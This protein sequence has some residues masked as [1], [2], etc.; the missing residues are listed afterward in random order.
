MSDR[1]DSKR[2]IGPPI[3]YGYTF[4]GKKPIFFFDTVIRNNGLP[5]SEE[6]LRKLVW[7]CAHKFASRVTGECFASCQ[8]GYFTGER[9]LE[10]AEFADREIDSFREK[11]PEYNRSYHIA[12]FKDTIYHESEEIFRVKFT[13]L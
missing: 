11:C 13:R 2:L 9:A 10:A 6:K 7:Y 12:V 3:R 5:E 4:E 1:I 8:D